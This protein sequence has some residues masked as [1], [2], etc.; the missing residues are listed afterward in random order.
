[1]TKLSS[2]VAGLLLFCIA[3]DNSPKEKATPNGL[4]YSVLKTGD[5]KIPKKEEILVFDYQLKDSKDSVWGDTFKDGI[6]AASMIGDTAVLDTEDGMT[7]MF[8]ELSKG[9]SVKTTMPIRDFFEKLVRAP[10]PPQV[11]SSGTVTYTI[12]VRE[13]MDLQDFQTF[14]TKKVSDRDDM[15]INKYIAE[16]KIAPQKDTTGLQFVIHNTTGKE[17]PTV[18]DCIEVAYAGRL[19]K[20]GRPVDQGTITL[21]LGQFVPGWQ[22]GFPKLSVGDSATFYIPSRLGYG[23]RGSYPVI[24]P[25]AVL[26]FNVKLLAIKP[27]DQAAGACK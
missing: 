1:M 4:K 3:C 15:E 26:I 10:V 12:S 25:D 16:N 23:P 8:R 13:V 22:V 18:E 7:Q 21:Q 5:G 9:D 11:D 17:K 24:P 6:P 20:D 27:F 19:L 2:I 14:R